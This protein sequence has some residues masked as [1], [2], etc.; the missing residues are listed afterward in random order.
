MIDMAQ[1]DSTLR[2]NDRE[3]K[4]Y[5]VEDSD[6]NVYGSFDSHSHAMRFCLK[7]L[8]NRRIISKDH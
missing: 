4:Y 8:D 7:D 1:A 6:G 3:I 5:Y 2:N